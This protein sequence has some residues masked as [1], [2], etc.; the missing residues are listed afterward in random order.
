MNNDMVF[1]NLTKHIA[2]DSVER[3]RRILIAPNDL[4]YQA[5]FSL[6]TALQIMPKVRSS[7]K[8]TTLSLSLSKA[9]VERR[10]LLSYLKFYVVPLLVRFLSFI[11]FRC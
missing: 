5:W 3:R 9:M 8:S 6:V 11:F 4:G 1:L 7:I 2:L 10:G